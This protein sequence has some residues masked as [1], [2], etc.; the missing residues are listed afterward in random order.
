MTWQGTKDRIRHAAT[1]GWQWCRREITPRRVVA[2]MALATLALL[3]TVTVEA[4][5][6]AR[7]PSA[8]ERA[9]SAL[10][11]RP[12]SWNGSGGAPVALAALHEGVAE[13][14]LP[15][16]L[17]EIPDHLVDA[18]LAVEDQ[19]FHE[20]GGLDIRRIGGALLANIRAGGIAQGG[21]TITQQLAK[22]LFLGAERTPIR[23]LREAAMALV[24]ERRHSKEEILEAY[25]NE[26][27]LGHDRGAAIHGVGAAAR[28]Y[29][30]KDVERVVL[31][32]AATLAAMIRAP[33]R[34]LPARH[35]DDLRARR[36]LVLQLMADQGRI[37]SRSQEQSARV[38]VPTRIHPARRIEG[39]W[40]RDLVQADLPGRLPRRGVAVYTTLDARLQQA[41]ATALQRGLAQAGQ[42]AAQ[43]ALVALDP[44]TGDILALVG[45][46]DYGGSQ[47]N[48][49]VQA[50]RQPGSAFKPFVALA[51]LEREG[52]DAPRYTLASMIE[53]TPVSVRTP[54]GP[55]RPANY[56]GEYRGEVTLRQ[57]M[58]QSLNVPFARLGLA[59]GPERVART[60][61]RLGIGSPLQPVPALAL[62]ASEVTLLELTRAYGVFAAGGT[63]ADT[64][65]ILGVSRGEDR[66]TP[67]REGEARR[68]ADPAAAWLVTSAL[69]GA[70]SNGTGRGM[71][72][73]GF[74][75][76]TGTSNDWRD[77]W[78]VA[79]TP[80]I[81]I[82]VWVGHD[83]GRSLH[84]SG[85]QLAVPIAARFVEEARIRP[86][87]FEMPEGIE[88]AYV[89]GGG[90]FSGCGEEEYFLEGTAPRTGPCWNFDLADLG[91]RFDWDREPD[92]YEDRQALRRAQR[93]LRD[94]AR[95]ELE[96]L[97][98]LEIRGR[99]LD[100]DELR[101]AQEWLR[102]LAEGELE[103]LVRAAERRLARIQ[104]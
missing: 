35:T 34:L 62:G 64:R 49:A 83:D 7:I 102:E 67:W 86:R 65:T 87:E 97:E 3:V 101:E 50:R 84:Q 5:V 20:H 104:P 11:T 45:G 88:T 14:R 8:A 31:S 68:V 81:V 18:V 96:R 46:R 69:Q 55:W 66:A 4:L 82:G 76:K 92:R 100:R 25:L 85:A 89:G 77:A 40:L 19:R 94:R 90:W 70:V 58:E 32:E 9:P 74:A 47:F 95:E 44:R 61:Q 37:S 22:N 21:S 52:R 78:F 72:R 56:D 93:Q 30:G 13:Y 57:A 39:R 53:D 28:Y 59:I 99:R 1:A 15:V 98:R 51:A 43:A 2:G 36:N 10:Y 103:R 71:R 60:A 80:E 63:L 17:D 26:I 16:A 41:A 79:Y 33:N 12:E 48:R 91:E 6:R 27:Y 38:A 75:G 42:P 24:L 29:F 23:K 54:Q 73:D